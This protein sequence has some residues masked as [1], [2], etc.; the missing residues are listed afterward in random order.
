MVENYNSEVKKHR[1]ITD[2]SDKLA[3]RRMDDTYIKWT[4][5]LNNK[6]VQNEILDVD[7]N[8]V[9]LSM[10]RPFTKKWLFYDEDIIERPGQY[11][12]IMGLEN[13]LI[14]ITGKGASRDFSA[15]VIDEVPNLDLMEKG[16]GFLR[17]IHDNDGLFKD[18]TSNI[19]EQIKEILNLT[20][21]QI[22][23]YV[24]AV[25]HSPEYK[26]KYKSDLQKNF[27]RI[28]IL[29]NKQEFVEIGKKLIELHLNYEIIEPYSDV[30]V[31]INKQTPSYKVKKMRFPKRNEK[32][33]II[34]NSDI[35]ISNIPEKAYEY[36]VNGRSAIEWIMDQYQVKTDKKSGISDD[37]NLYSEDEKYIFNLLLSIINLSV[38]TVDLVNSL[39]PLE[40]IDE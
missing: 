40:I 38:Q 34:F 22:F 25:L 19:H 6:F 10:Y 37:P 33:T 26:E 23:S 13:K 1:N 17:Y 2:K 7:L 32:E 4:V 11:K 20:D 28:P 14:Y 24:Y 8:K 39:P 27:P 16:Q 12:D 35:R 30:D 31:E 3:L 5:K 36:V 9:R 29:K 21:D 18:Q 15:L